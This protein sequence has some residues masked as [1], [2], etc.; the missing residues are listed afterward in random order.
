[1]SSFFSV[2]YKNANGKKRVQFHLK[3]KTKNLILHVVD[4]DSNCSGG[5]SDYPK[6]F[7]TY[8]DPK[9]DV[10]CLHVLHG[11][12]RT[13]DVEKKFLNIIIRFFQLYI[14]LALLSKAKDKN[15]GPDP[16]IVFRMHVI[17]IRNTGE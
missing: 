15:L 5:D 12:L 14:I 11:G 9:L 7:N 1:M 10:Y 6:S 2:N 17:R 13:V 3:N 16:A 4:P 8:L